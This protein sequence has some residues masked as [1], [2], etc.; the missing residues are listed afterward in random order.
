MHAYLEVKPQK[1]NRIYV[2]V[3][4]HK[5]VAL[6]PNPTYFF[7]GSRFH[8]IQWSFFP[9]KDAQGCSLNAAPAIEQTFCHADESEKPCFGENKGNM[10]MEISSAFLCGKK[11]PVLTTVQL[12]IPIW[13]IINQMVGGRWEKV[14]VL[15]TCEYHQKE[16][17]EISVPNIKI[18]LKTHK[19]QFFF[20]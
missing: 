14:E 11:V 20:L 1:I 6:Y 10:I 13:L 3:H 16:A 5:T 17:Q 4:L 12:V 15:S 7:L 18:K 9:G 8:L 19:I 2:H